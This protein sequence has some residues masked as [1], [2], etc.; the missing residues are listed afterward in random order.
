MSNYPEQ[1]EPPPDVGHDDDDNN[2]NTKNDDSMFVSA[3]SPATV[4]VSLSGGEDDDENPF[5]SSTTREKTPTNTTNTV[6]SYVDN[7]K[8]LFQPDKKTVKVDEEDKD[9]FGEENTSYNQQPSDSPSVPI[10]VP[11]KQPST[12]PPTP[13]KQETSLYSTDSSVNAG[14]PL[15]ANVPFESQLSSSTPTLKSVLSEPSTES[16]PVQ[17]R[18]HE[19]N[20][21][22]TVS[23]PTKVGEGMS[24]YLTYRITTKTTLPMFKKS[25]FSVQRRFSDFLGLHS[26]LV[27][28]HLHVGVIIPSPP[29]KDSISMAKVKI[30]KDESIPTDFIDRRRA[31]LERYLN[32]LVRHDKLIEDSDVR[33]FIEMPS[34][35][36]KSTNTQALSGAGVLHQW[37]E[38]KHIF[39]DDLHKHLK[40]LYNQFNTLFSQRKEAGHALKIFSIS[41]NHLAT[42]EEHPLL[43][44]ALI[45]LAN[46]EEKLDQVHNEQA[47]Q[48]Y[49]ILTELIKEYVS[50]LEMVQL[51]FHERIK[52][53][54]QWLN[55]E[56]TLKKKRETKTKLEQSPKGADKLPQ[57]EMEIRDWDG[58]VVRSKEDFEKISTTIK[59]EMDVFEQTR[60]DDFKKAVDSYLNDLLEEQNKILQIWEA[61]L[62]EA[63][64]I[65]V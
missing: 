47:L 4:D 53:H 12:P 41:L 26:K 62:P 39:I 56:E 30:S 13:I 10:V 38:E 3:M 18:S 43:S 22:I 32:R 35:L 24:S 15:Q 61:Y 28:K 8:N 27:H 60:I 2:T 50:L 63:N 64:K 42:T 52:V 31:L 20:I 48:E 25:E 55:A 45:E 21:E 17:K 65:I 16:K 23:D 46:L 51:A 40:N 29:E 1:N 37:F 59:Q 6:E 57:A 44:S 19:N 34:E 33:E 49:S 58:K 54:Q 9:L 14:Q 7:E 11:E 36:P 5:G